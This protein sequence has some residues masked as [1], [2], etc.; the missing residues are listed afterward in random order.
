[1]NSPLL[2]WKNVGVDVVIVD[3]VEIPTNPIFAPPI[4]NILYASKTFLPFDSLKLHEI[5]G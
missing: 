5:Y 1:M 4:S 2:F 3:G